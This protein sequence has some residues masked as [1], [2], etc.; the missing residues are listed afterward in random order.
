[1][2]FKV[3]LPD[4]IGSSNEFMWVFKS[5]K[6]ALGRQLL[7]TVCQY[8]EIEESQYFGL[9]FYLNRKA[10]RNS[11]LGTCQNEESSSGNNQDGLDKSFRISSSSSSINNSYST[12]FCGCPLTNSFNPCKVYSYH[13]TYPGFNPFFIDVPVS[14]FL[15]FWNHKYMDFWVFAVYDDNLNA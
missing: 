2:E 10:D 5:M 15:F 13:S 11:V 4:S 14:S 6:L 8:L 3:G 1:M 12:R 7:D 9:V